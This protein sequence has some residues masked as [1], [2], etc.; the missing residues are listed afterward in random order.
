ATA[1]SIP[2]QAE[3]A[4]RDRL[5]GIG[6]GLLADMI[7]HEDSGAARGLLERTAW[8]P[9]LA[10]ALDLLGSLPAG[11]QIVVRDGSAV[12]IGSAIALG[13][14]DGGLERRAALDRLES[15][16]ARLERAAATADSEAAAV[17]EQADAARRTLDEARAEEALVRS[18]RRAAE[19]SE[20][21]AG[22]ALERVARE[23]AWQDAAAGRTEVE[24]ERQRA[25][26]GVLDQPPVA[27]RMPGGPV[28]AAAAAGSIAGGSPGGG[29]AL[30]TWELRVADL[31]TRRD[32]LGLAVAERGQARSAAEADH[33]RATAGVALSQDRIEHADRDLAELARHESELV[34]ERDQVAVEL[35]AAGS[36]EATLGRVLAEVRAAD[37][38]DRGRLAQAEAATS[39]ARDQL[40][41]AEER[42]RSAEVGEFESRL[43][44]DLVR[45]QAVS[46]IGGLGLIGLAALGLAA[47]ER[48]AGS[49]EF[50]DGP[51][52]TSSALAEEPGLDTIPAALLEHWAAQAPPAEPP[53]PARLATLRRRYH[54]LGAANPMAIEEYAELKARLEGL[55]GQ[56]HDLREAIGTTRTLID[57]LGTMV[58][59]Q[60]R[61]TFRNLEVAFDAR[62]K[63]LFGGG[64][65]RLELTDPED[66]STTGVEIVARPPGKK[67]QALAM[68][69]GGERALT[70]VALLFAMLE[71][72]PVPFCVMD[73]VDAALDEANIGRFADALRSLASE[74]QFIVITHNRGTIEAAD[75][76]YGVTVGDD[77]VSRVISLRLDEATALASAA[78]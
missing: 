11:W 74:T 27:P 17:G 24:L 35:A 77:S 43:A 40:R 53:G 59:D 18:A 76:L 72:R 15:E 12:L 13:R 58:A 45:D 10:G 1:R 69:S 9:D 16:L 25:A 3:V 8:T 31:R 60:F 62:F 39:S 38:E 51:G 30:E 65:A 67:P 20:R 70:A 68:L 47:P 57:E 63:Q 32:E 6:G 2:A 56:E 75:A 34:L 78:S 29:S 49:P 61:S 44:Q 4:F 46:E 54:E 41:A 64:Y 7:R 23:A 33:A 50:P 21:V 28:S 48:D 36:H 55:Q 71:I 42:F 37:S 26:L 52:P 66:L 22:R 14:A 19:E 73:E 5:T